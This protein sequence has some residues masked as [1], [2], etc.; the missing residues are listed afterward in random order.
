MRE[1]KIQNTVVYWHRRRS[2]NRPLDFGFVF[3][4]RPLSVKF[5]FDEGENFGSTWRLIFGSTEP[6]FS[7][8]VIVGVTKDL[9]GGSKSAPSSSLNLEER[10]M[11]DG[12]RR[13]PGSAKESYLRL[14]SFHPVQ[15]YVHY[16]RD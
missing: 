14:V 3:V 8:P 1:K 11:G 15:S 6:K 5:S 4:I 7:T 12:E 2:G 10:P 9:L 16:R 13:T